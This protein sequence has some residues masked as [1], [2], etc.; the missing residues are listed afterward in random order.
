MNEQMRPVPLE[1][2][3]VQF[4]TWQAVQARAPQSS[5][6]RASFPHRF[7]LEVVVCVAPGLM[8]VR[9]GNLMAG[10]RIF[11]VLLL[12]LLLWHLLTAN[13]VRYFS[14]IASTIPVL[15][16]FRGRF[17]FNIFILITL[18]GFVGWAIISPQVLTRVKRNR[19]LLWLIA[20]SIV[21]WWLSFLWTGTYS[22]NLRTL[23]LAMTAAIVYLLSKQPGVLKVVLTGLAISVLFLAIALAP[24]SDRLGMAVVDDISIGNPIH[25]GL[26]AGLIFILVSA[27]KGRWLYTGRGNLGRVVLW[28]SSLICLLL[29][30]SRG[31]WLMVG[32]VL[33]VL[34]ISVP[35]E[36][37]KILGSLIM[38]ALVICALM[39]SGHGYSV[40][41]Y[42]DK[43][44]STDRTLSQK[45]TL[46]SDQWITVGRILNDSPILGAG[47]GQGYNANVEYGSQ[48]FVFHSL[49]LQ[50]AAETGVAG[51]VIVFLFLGRVL[52]DARKHLRTMGEVV[53][54]LG[55]VAFLIV[56]LSVT[57]FDPLSG[58]YL[59]LA[60]LGG[61]TTHF[62]AVRATRVVTPQPLTLQS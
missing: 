12:S 25:M 41:K 15:M 56:G 49:Y 57:G 61:P 53:P 62:R 13:F 24:Y 6:R 29:S 14:L 4:T 11:F 52:V 32:V 44:A 34:C 43:V 27:D 17:L 21:Y 50:I 59:G 10:I 20:F 39:L 48:H 3:Q 26:G 31:G 23:D 58:V 5:R 35:R 33:I 18:A 47:L 45:T 22:A 16:P 40:M 60:L 38:I 54:L 37:K 7:L 8:V 51:L 2:Q 46:R 9:L 1:E 36:R 28:L 19:S 42:Y 30:T 55:I